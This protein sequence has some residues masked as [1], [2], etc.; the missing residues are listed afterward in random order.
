MIK[1][2]RKLSKEVFGRLMSGAFVCIRDV[3]FEDSSGNALD[4]E[5]PN[6]IAVK[7]PLGV[8]HVKQ[9]AAVA[10]KGNRYV[11]EHIELA[12]SGDRNQTLQATRIGRPV[13]KFADG[14][15]T[16]HVS[17]NNWVGVPVGICPCDAR[18]GRVTI[19][20]GNAPDGA[21]VMLLGNT[22]DNDAYI[23]AADAVS[24]AADGVTDRIYTDGTG[25]LVTEGDYLIFGTSGGSSAP[26]QL[27]V[28]VELIPEV[29]GQSVQYAAFG[30]I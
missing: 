21:P 11:N 16:D 13:F 10:V 6:K 24:V 26:S 19:Y 5:F 17:A 28:E 3:P 9:M 25:P 30:S 15:D 12:R 27:K 29:S 20:Q 23:A 1:Q 2:I 8:T 7:M 4:S 14:D 22:G 18:I